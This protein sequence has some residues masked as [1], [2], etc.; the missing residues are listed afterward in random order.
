LERELHSINQL[1]Y[2]LPADTNVTIFVLRK[3]V[4]KLYGKVR[5]TKRGYI[6][7]IL[8]DRDVVHSKAILEAIPDDN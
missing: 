3:Q 6:L 8:C 2:S 5:H 7:W 1:T 4:W